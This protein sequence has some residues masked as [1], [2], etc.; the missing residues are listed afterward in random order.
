MVCVAYGQPMGFAGAG[1]HLTNSATWLGKVVV[2]TITIIDGTSP[3]FLGLL[4]AL[5]M[6]K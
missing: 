1:D 2:N 3:V 4:S 5:G 6:Q